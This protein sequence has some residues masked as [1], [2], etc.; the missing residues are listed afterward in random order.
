VISGPVVVDA[1]VVVEYLVELKFTRDATRFFSRL[2][3]ENSDLQLYAPDLLYP[4]CVSALRKL[5]R[6]KAIS[7]SA[8]AR[9]VDR[10]I[11]L[12]IAAASTAALMLDAWQLRHSLTIYDACYVL[13]ARRLDAPLLTADERL[14][15]ARSRSG[16]RTL[17]LGN[18]G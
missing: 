4:E 8:G 5:V 15:R 13:L 9:A 2:T 17:F 18:L 11:R 1:S 14:S 3:H 12:P 7:A 6:L 10:L 16:D